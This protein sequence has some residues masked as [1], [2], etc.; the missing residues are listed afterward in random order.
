MNRTQIT[1]TLSPT[2][3]KWDLIKQKKAFIHERTPLFE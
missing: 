3:N 1:Q 2:T